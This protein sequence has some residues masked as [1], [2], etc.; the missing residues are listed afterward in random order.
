MYALLPECHWASNDD[1]DTSG[2]PGPAL[3]SFFFCFRTDKP[4]IDSSSI[5]STLKELTMVIASMILYVSPGRCRPR[6]GAKWRK[7]KHRGEGMTVLKIITLCAR[8][9]KRK[10]ILL[11]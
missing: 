1:W 7:Q 5:V 8:Y 3:F 2:T 6:F 11:I 10:E 9:A 4:S